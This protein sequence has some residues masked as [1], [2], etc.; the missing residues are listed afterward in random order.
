M[1]IGQE[2]SPALRASKATFLSAMID[3]RARNVI[4]S[5]VAEF[6]EK[7]WP[8]SFCTV[9]FRRLA[10]EAEIAATTAEMRAR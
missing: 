4:A 2:D 6:A 10:Q 5:L 7:G 1:V 9:F 8:D 3:H